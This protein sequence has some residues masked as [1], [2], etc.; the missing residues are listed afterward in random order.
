VTVSNLS[1]NPVAHSTRAVVDAV[2]V[3]KSVY[4][5]QTKKL[6]IA[7]HSGDAGFSN[8][9]FSALRPEIKPDAPAYGVFAEPTS[10]CAGV[11]PND[12]VAAASG[13]L[14]LNQGVVAS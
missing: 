13:R 12:R 3:T 6:C 7:A 1:S 2:V 8:P 5:P 9:W 11:A 10:T 4:D 14:V